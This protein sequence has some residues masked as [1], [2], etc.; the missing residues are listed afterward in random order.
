MLKK[1]VSLVIFCIILFSSLS[2]FLSA[3]DYELADD[4]AS[5]GA[6]YLYNYENGLCM[7]EHG[8]DD[9]ISPSATVKMMTACVALESGIDTSNTVTVT[10]EMIDGVSGRKMYL[11]AGDR[12]TFLDLIY[13]TVCGG[14]NDAA[15]ALAL[16]VSPSLS[17][18]IDKMNAKA[19]ELDMTATY[20]S[21]VTGMDET[22]MLTCALDVIKLSNYLIKNE[23]FIAVS[24]TVSYKLSDSATCDTKTISNRSS[25]VASYKGL[26]N[27]S[28]GSGNNGDCAV[29]YY[30]NSELSFL[31]IVM[32]AQSKN[33]GDTVNYAEYYSKKLLAHALNDYSYRTVL[34]E[35]SVVA[36][37]PVLYSSLS[38]NVNLYLKE[39]LNVYIPDSV[40]ETADLTYNCYI[41]G[42]ELK[43]PL[44]SGDTVGEMIVSYG[45]RILAT[46]PLTV[47]TDVERSG[48]LY[49]LDLIKN[50][51]LSRAFVFSC[52][53]FVCLMTAYFFY[54]QKQLKAIHRSSKKQR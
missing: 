8:T 13:A 43:A 36:S 4:D 54:R 21:N 53:I 49:F 40:D 6:Y 31:C 19:K 26:S 7:A 32:N 46:V 37:L 22:G 41:Y 16:S 51:V 15:T 1:T 48:F 10:S 39:P 12:L 20:Y 50:Y 14:Y 34:T 23:T 47:R 9:M 29:L 28:S 45:G 18:F 5:V 38:E 11:K 3:A 44:K 33:V 24:S 17:D 52:I 25:L 30:N 2:F 27:L 42:D 35:K